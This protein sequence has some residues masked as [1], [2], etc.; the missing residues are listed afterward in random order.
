MNKAASV[1]PV[2]EL[3]RKRAPR[4]F[5]EWEQFYFESAVQ[6]KKSGQRISH[7][8]LEDLGR[9]LYVKLSEVVKS[10]LFSIKEQECIDYVFNL[11]LNRTY[12]GY[13]TEVETVYGQLEQAL[14]VSIEPAPDEWD[15]TY[16]VDFFIRIGERHIGIQIKPVAT[17]KSIN[18]YQWEQMHRRNHERFKAQ[19]GGEV[20]FVYSRAV[21]K[22]KE[23]VNQ[24]VLQK[25]KAE[26]ERLSI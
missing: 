11:V 2:A 7:E 25:I 6:K 12:E 16:N 23:I 17:G 13:R 10:E 24:D 9:R 21:G 14:G 5:E 19:F 22:K 1:G 26:I 4:E 18:D 8:Y 20:F 3:I 15:R